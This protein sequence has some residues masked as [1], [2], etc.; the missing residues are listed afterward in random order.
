MLYQNPTQENAQ[1]D[2][3]EK[4]VFDEMD[5]TGFDFSDDEYTKAQKK[6]KKERK[7][8]KRAKKGEID[9]DRIDEAKK[10]FPDAVKEIEDLDYEVDYVGDTELKFKY[11][12]TEA[13]NY[14]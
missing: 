5:F 1:F 7:R 2:D 8:G 10:H 3:D 4:P 11:R 6:A 13:Q 12:E 9:D 14:G